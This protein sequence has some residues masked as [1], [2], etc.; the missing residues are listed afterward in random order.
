MLRLADQFNGM[1]ILSIHAGQPIA[2]V[3]SLLIKAQNLSIAGFYCQ[4][5]GGEP[6][7]ILQPTDIR[8][9]N[10]N[11]LIIN[12]EEDFS[13]PEDLLRLQ[14]VVEMN[15]QLLGKPVITESKKK[16]GKVTNFV[17]DETSWKIVKL[18]VTRPAWKAVFN[19]ALIIDRIHI[20]SVS[21]QKIVVKDATVKE[22]GR[23]TAPAAIPNPAA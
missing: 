14:D 4:Q 21:Q 19:S 17:I 23:E 12:H 6:P 11:G 3:S 18:H 10:K 2:N 13:A 9:I 20:V 1:P 5:T 22:S 8:E 16:L 15:F 7:T